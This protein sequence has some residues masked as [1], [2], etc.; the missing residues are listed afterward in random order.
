MACQMYGYTVSTCICMFILV[1]VDIS[2]DISRKAL[3]MTKKSDD[4]RLKQ[5]VCSLPRSQIRQSHAS[6]GQNRRSKRD[7]T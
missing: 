5:S 6:P 2:L 7:E 3:G 1:H 4:S